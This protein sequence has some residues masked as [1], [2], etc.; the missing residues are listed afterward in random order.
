MFGRNLPVLKTAALSAAAL[1]FAA[2]PALAQ[3]GGHGG[4][5]HG[6]G[7]GHSG[8]GGGHSA[9]SFHG[10]SFHGGG[11]NF[12]GSTFH[13]SSF[14]GNNFNHSNFY[15][16]SLYFSPGF[17]GFGYYPFYGS[18]Y[19]GSYGGISSYASLY[20]NYGSSYYDYLGPYDDSYVAPYAYSR[21]YPPLP[22]D[23]DRRAPAAPVDDKAHVRVLVP[24]GAE[25]WFDGSKTTQAGNSREYVSPSLAPD[26]TYSYEVRAR[27]MDNGKPVEETRKV[28]VRAGSQATVDFTQPA[29]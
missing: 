10:S 11:S 29:P 14:H 9:A 3:H 6:G 23:V 20:P 5:G 15:R 8:G 28:M 25:V 22:A 12:H 1:L 17:Y 16:S 27:W 26:T 24:S 19:P 21:S 4:G 2:G 7:G 13:G 18:Y